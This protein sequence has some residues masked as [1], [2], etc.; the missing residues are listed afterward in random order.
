MVILLQEL[1]FA[2]GRLVGDD[3]A[4]VTQLCSALLLCE[5]VEPLDLRLVLLH[6]R[7]KRE[8]SRSTPSGR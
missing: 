8:N 4:A 1:V 3:F 7:N 5:V 6:A 2:L